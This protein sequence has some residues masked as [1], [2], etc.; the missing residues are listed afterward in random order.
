MVV[1]SEGPNPR[2]PVRNRRSR[3][4]T[5]FK[6]GSVESEGASTSPQTTPERLARR[7]RRKR[8][9]TKK[10]ED[11]AVETSESRGGQEDGKALEHPLTNKSK[12]T[13]KNPAQVVEQAIPKDRAA[14]ASQAAA[15]TS[16]TPKEEISKPSSPAEAFDLKIEYPAFQTSGILEFEPD[17]L[18]PSQAPSN[19]TARAPQGSDSQPEPGN[20][21]EPAH[22]ENNAPSKADPVAKSKV[23]RVS[24]NEFLGRRRPRRVLPPLPPLPVAEGG[25]RPALAIFFEK[26]SVPFLFNRRP[27]L[28]LAALEGRKLE[29]NPK[30]DTAA[31]REE[32]RQAFKEDMEWEWPE[33]EVL[34]SHIDAYFYR[35]DG[36]KVF[37]DTVFVYNPSHEA[38]S[39]F[40]RLSLAARWIGQIPQWDVENWNDSLKEFEE[41][42]SDKN[43]RTE[44]GKFKDASFYE[45]DQV[46]PTCD[47]TFTCSC[48]V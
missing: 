44:R 11:A 12:P 41:I 22:G 34:R 46:L 23:R 10:M 28:Q 36:M 7:A 33:R 38:M 2:R 14:A 43:A 16:A 3:A 15:A 26:Q 5:S 45:F 24:Y 4:A 9:Y 20:T 39:E 48:E 1:R 32:F 6:P 25:T 18:E 17:F 40:L 27:Y 37:E 35:F 8:R 47:L 21:T 29:E 30:F 42:W 19:Q 13:A 31:L